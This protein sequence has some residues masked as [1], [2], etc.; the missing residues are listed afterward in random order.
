MRKVLTF[1]CVLFLL[2]FASAPALAQSGGPGEESGPIPIRE[3]IVAPGETLFSIARRYGTTVDAI[4]H[5]NQIPDPRQIYAGQ[6]LLIPSALGPVEAW[7]THVVR[8]GETIQGIARQYGV[9]WRKLALANALINPSLLTAGRVLRIPGNTKMALPGALHVVQPGET[10]TR[11]AFQ[12][13][14]SVWDL[15]EANWNG[16]PPLDLPGMWLLIPGARPSWM[17]APFQQIDVHPLPISQGDTLVI[18]IRTDRPVTL[19]GT[20]FDRPVYFAEENGVYYALV[21]VHAFT[22]PGVYELTLT[23]TDGNGATT[24]VGVEVLVTE[25]TYGHERI[26]V[27]PSRANLLDPQVIAAERERLRQVR[28]LFTP[29]RYWNGP[30][31]LP[32]EAAISSV[33]GT[34]RSYNGGP[35]N[36]YHEGVDFDVGAGAAVYAP[37][38]GVVV[39][40]E[41]LA[42]RG[43]AVVIDHGWGVLTGYWHLSR[44][45]V[46]VGQQVRTGDIIGRVGNT[47]L[48]T[49][50]HLHWDFWVGG[51]N[52]NGLRWTAA[53]GPA[54]LYGMQR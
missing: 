28:S 31:R 4:A 17:P 13:R 33:F 15:L 18:A 34:R 12:R 3:H 53:D 10:F 27:P 30:F 47:G 7:K 36:S 20:L 5:A 38:D 26:D 24:A 40:A 2:Q 46:T 25:G 9:D 54:T 41:P 6:R 52:V 50:A 42:V 35:Y 45:E 49:G 23:A 39:L 43:N 51:I 44:I 8:P 19:Q 48:S 22:D 1:L 11:L 16:R 29:Q 21:G 37:A 32:V 14:T